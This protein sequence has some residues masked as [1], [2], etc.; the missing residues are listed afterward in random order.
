MHDDGC[1]V[2]FVCV[3]QG[4]TTG[5]SATS[6]SASLYAKAPSRIK[7]RRSPLR[8]LTDPGFWQ[9]CSHSVCSRFYTSHYSAL[10]LL[11]HPCVHPCLWLYLMDICSK[12]PFPACVFKNNSEGHEARK[13]RSVR[14]QLE[15]LQKRRSHA[16]RL[17][18]V[19]YC[20]F[21][22]CFRF[23]REDLDAF[24][25]VFLIICV[26]VGEEKSV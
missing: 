2:M 7:L 3:A 22:V 4:P 26:V 24:L 16:R 21:A 18:G 1:A 8:T 10:Y 13:V 6:L 17:A 5:R 23:W 9:D 15:R 20:S 25:L 19:S 11:T 12:C 14:R